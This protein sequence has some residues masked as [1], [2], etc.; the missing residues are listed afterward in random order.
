[1]FR[2]RWLVLKVIVL[3]AFAILPYAVC[4][5]DNPQWI[6]AGIGANIL[7]GR[8]QECVGATGCFAQDGN[9]VDTLGVATATT[10]MKKTQ[11]PY[12]DCVP[13]SNVSYNT[14]CNRTGSYYACLYTQKFLDSDG[15]DQNQLKCWNYYWVEGCY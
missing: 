13:I 3:A 10:F 4:S 15:C 6:C 2:N 1:M 5:A 11:M 7:E 12:N 8:I 9:C 14:W